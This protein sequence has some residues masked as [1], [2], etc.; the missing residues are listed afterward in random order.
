MIWLLPPPFSPPSLSQH[1][2]SHSQSFSVSPVEHTYGRKGGGGG[3]SQ[4]M[5]Q[6]ECLAL[7]I[8]L[9]TLWGAGL[10]QV[11]SRTLT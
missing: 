7:Y 5:R 8:E 11:H 9:N 4:I 3:R 6:R 10:A 1:V 2:V